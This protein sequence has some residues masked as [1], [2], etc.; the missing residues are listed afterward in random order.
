M[1]ARSVIVNQVSVIAA[2]GGNPNLRICTGA[3]R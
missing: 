2:L 3:E 1:V